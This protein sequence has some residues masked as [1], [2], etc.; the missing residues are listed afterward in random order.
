MIVR[1][2]AW[3]DL[4]L[5]TAVALKDVGAQGFGCGCVNLVAV[6]DRDDLSLV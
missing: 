2:A 6:I 4:E 3:D 1:L 5:L